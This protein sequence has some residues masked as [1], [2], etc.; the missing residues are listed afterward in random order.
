MPAE[1]M[2]QGPIIEKDPDW[3]C[4]LCLGCYLPPF[5]HILAVIGLSSVVG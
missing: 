5:Y 4:Y 1:H 3:Y 2:A